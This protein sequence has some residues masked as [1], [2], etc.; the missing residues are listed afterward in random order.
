MPHRL[1]V[2]TLLFVF[3]ASLA[4][5]ASGGI[6]VST[7]YDPLTSFP[8]QASY[9]WDDRANK[10]PSDP[11]IV[12]LDLDPLVKG[13]AEEE[14]AAR[15]YRAVASGAPDY[16][17]SYEIVVHTWIGVDNSRSVG[18]LSL[19]LV[20]ADTGRRVWLGFGRAEVHVGLTRAE[21]KQRL[22]EALAEMLEKFPP[23]QRGS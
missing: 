22:R 15:G 18:S 17:L 6:E 14:F 13:A 20:E 4:G 19:L 11:R 2:V 5:C 12:E 8:A 9:A 21:R 10:L 16:R 3:L 1:H 23:A 7:T